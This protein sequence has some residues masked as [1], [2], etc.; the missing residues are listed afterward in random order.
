MKRLLLW[1]FAVV[2]TVV[3][4]ALVYGTAVEPRLILDEREYEVVLPRLPA[5]SSG[6]R[7]AVFSDLQVGMWLANTRMVDRIVQR[8]IERDPDVLLIA[9]DFL[10][11]DRVEVAV[12]VERVREL[13][14]P[15]EEAEIPTFAV[16]GNHDHAVGGAE[17]VTTALEELGI[18][19]LENEAVPLSAVGEGVEAA[20]DPALHVVGIG[21]FRPGLSD[22]V[23]A[24]R[25]VPEEVPRVVV[26]H[27]PASFSAIP[28]DSAPLSVA[29]H[30]H[31]GQIAVPGTP[32]WSYLELRMEERVV[33]DGFAPESYGA[34]GN[35]LFVTCG[36]GFSR[37]PMRIGAAP[38]LVVFELRGEGSSVR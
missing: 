26:M 15:L 3:V 25:N 31:C 23:A 32:G 27:N 28:V 12:Q 14:A 34:A 18:Q 5:G 37:L 30:T 29:G 38:Q 36:I 2:A 17:E 6:T 16:L 13:L 20:Q 33:V 7:V 24:L 21:P 10:Y 11:G 35:G 22:P 4:A 19:V 8:T 9:G 1:A